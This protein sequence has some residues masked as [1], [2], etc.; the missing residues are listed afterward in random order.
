MP[1]FLISWL[2]FFRATE[3]V[4]MVSWVNAIQMLEQKRKKKVLNRYSSE[5]KILSS[6]MC[7]NIG[8][9]GESSKTK[10]I[11]TYGQFHRLEH[12]I[13]YAYSCY[14]LPIPHENLQ[15]NWN[16]NVRIHDFCVVEKH[17]FAFEPKYDPF[18]RTI[19]WDS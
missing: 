15:R 4:L 6:E 17:K 8:G 10:W 19:N 5:W 1:W 12:Y 7:R 11:R 9:W 13:F 3:N 14:Y 2:L 18:S 16:I